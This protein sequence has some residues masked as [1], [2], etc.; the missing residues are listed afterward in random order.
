MIRDHVFKTGSVQIIVNDLTVLGVLMLVGGE[1]TYK[2]R[3]IKLLREQF[4]LGL[5][6][7]KQFVDFIQA[8]CTLDHG[9]GEVLVRDTSPVVTHER[10]AYE[11]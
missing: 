9:T 2:V 5:Y 1:R 6:E 7:A 8:N 10:L 4:G 11:Y 3:A